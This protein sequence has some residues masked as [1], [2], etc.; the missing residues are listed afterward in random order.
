M[1]ASETVIA[2]LAL[3]HLGISKTIASLTERSQEALACLAFY[4]E[5]RDEMLRDF[6]WP[7]AAKF[8]ELTLVGED[9]TDEWGYSY[10]YPSD[11]L[12]LRRIFSGL[13]TDSRQS[14]VKYKL[15]SDDDGLLIYTDV[16]EPTCEYTRRFTD[17][18]RFPPDFVMALSFRLAFYIAPRVTAGDPWKLGARAGEL[19]RMSN[20]KAQGACVNEEKPDEVAESEFIRARESV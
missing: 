18:L 2:N 12:T 3:S 20:Q 1:A 5:A 15:G 10:R 8:A 19:W 11:C 7:F 9:P 4:E 6:P 13:R 14:Q 17:V 16:S